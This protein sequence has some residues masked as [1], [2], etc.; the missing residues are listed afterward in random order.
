M[1]GVI[2]L[3]LKNKEAKIDASC[4]GDSC[5]YGMQHHNKAEKVL[6]D[7]VGIS[8]DELERRLAA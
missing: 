1:R 2:T 8:L 5:P 4:L 3:K 6:C 7:F